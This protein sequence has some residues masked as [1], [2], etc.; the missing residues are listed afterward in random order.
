M[1]RLIVG[2][3]VTAAWCGFAANTWWVDCR[4]DGYDGHDGRTEAGALRTVQEAVAK[5]A[6]GDVVKVKP[7]VYDA[8]ATVDFTRGVAR[9]Q[10]TRPLRLVSTDGAAVTRIV[11]RHGTEKDGL[12][13]DAV[14]CIAA[15]KEAAGSEIVGF[16]LADGAGRHTNGADGFSGGLQCADCRP[17]GV[18]LVD[19]VVTNCVGTRGAGTFGG[20]ARR[21]LYVACRSF[22]DR[23]NCGGAVARYTDLVDCRAV[24]CCGGYL[25]DYPGRISG[26]RFEDCAASGYAIQGVTG[27]NVVENC[28][29]EV[30][31]GGRG[32]A[33]VRFKGC[34]FL[35][36]KA[37]RELPSVK[38]ARD[39]QD[40]IDRASAAGGGTVRLPVGRWVSEGLQLKSDVTLEIPEGCF[41]EATT[42]KFLWPCGRAF[43]WASGATNVA[44][45]GKGE[46]DT[47]GELY[48]FYDEAPGRISSVVMA[49]VKGLRIHDVTIRRSATW[50]LCLTRCEDVHVKGVK[51]RST[52][53]FNNDGIDIEAR[54]CLI[55]D[56]D[57]DSDDDAICFKPNRR[58]FPVE[59]VEVRNCLISSSC[60]FIK[61][62]TGSLAPVRRIRIHD[63]K[64]FARTYS[65]V[66]DYRRWRSRLAGG[67]EDCANGIA[68]IALEVVDGGSM[69]DVTIRNIEISGCQTPIFIRHAA[70]KRFCDPWKHESFLRNVLIENVKGSCVSRIASSITGIP[71]KRVEDIT[72]RN[73]DLTYPGGATAAMLAKPVP[74][75][76][77]C[78]PE[79]SCFGHV[80]PGW[81]FYV[82]HADGIR[83]ENV[84]VRLAKPDAR[85]QALVT[86]DATRVTCSGCNFSVPN[87]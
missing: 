38:F 40:R 48:P 52:V 76:E 2:V 13:A 1:R 10:L 8:G 35:L 19:C 47:H 63:C 84:K 17:G 80:L 51:I 73:I 28:R 23:G 77:G 26:C 74:E 39:I 67:M 9:V 16:T 27:T 6:A 57:I 37:Y 20:A 87:P 50:T 42:N 56:C 82:R 65:H 69:E 29:F 32:D 43:L 12:G 4:M 58:D 7:G 24:E 31:C 14:R 41:V 79:A 55:E 66:R 46:I 64:V 68:A 53:N 54:R 15:T 45:V 21:T 61:F 62:G 49:D 70:R 85:P 44:L 5:A 78:Y 30:R 81:A 18:T 75:R 22:N 36:P 33:A 83:F 11:G 34:E 71:G 3:F 25:V 59:D 72:L 86:D 60:N